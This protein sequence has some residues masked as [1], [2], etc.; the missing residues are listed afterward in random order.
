[1]STIDRIGLLR[2]EVER[3]TVISEQPFDSVAAK[4]AA[5]IGHPDM[6]AF[7]RD[8]ASARTSGDL[9]RIVHA[10]TGPSGFME[11]A[12]FDVGDILRKELG[13]RAP[14]ILRLVIGNPLIMKEMVK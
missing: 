13:E 14:K 8:V 5:A 2:F 3:T 1:M 12:R 9:E 4:L 11:M 6:S 10:A 7:S